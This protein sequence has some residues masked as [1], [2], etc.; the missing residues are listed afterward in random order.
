[1]PFGTSNRS[2]PAG[3]ATSPKANEPAISGQ[4]AS[5][6]EA[7][8]LEVASLQNQ[9]LELMR[10]FTDVLSMVDTLADRLKAGDKTDPVEVPAQT[11][12]TSSSGT[13][14]SMPPLFEASG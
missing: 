11:S 2:Q 6:V 4:L 8:K 1:M 12:G 14:T 10:Q 5:R 3:T 7:L 13:A 9:H